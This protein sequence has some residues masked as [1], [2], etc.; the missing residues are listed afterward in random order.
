MKFIRFSSV[1]NRIS[2]YLHGRICWAFVSQNFYL[3]ISY[4]SQILFAKVLF[5]LC[6]LYRLWSELKK[7]KKKEKDKC[8]CFSSLRVSFFFTTPYSIY[9]LRYHTACT[10]ESGV[11]P[12]TRY[13]RIFLE[14]SIFFA[15]KITILAVI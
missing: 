8:S 4:I 3:Q 11:E 5:L 10:S 1:L 15:A 6:W 2:I 13:T 7:K 12:K 9:M 14:I